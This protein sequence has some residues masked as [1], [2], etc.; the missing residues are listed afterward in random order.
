MA[1]TTSQLERKNIAWYVLFVAPSSSVDLTDVAA[2]KTAFSVPDNPLTAAEPATKLKLATGVGGLGQ[3]V[4]RPTPKFY[5]GTEAGATEGGGEEFAPVDINLDFLPSDPVHL[6]FY[7]GAL[8]S[9]VYFFR[10]SYQAAGLEQGRYFRT[11]LTSK[12]HPTPVEGVE[13]FNVTVTPEIITNS[14]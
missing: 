5:V 4:G 7:N 8:L 11:S 14:V 9:K 12:D 13:T 3:S 10:H 1:V 2:V 6:G